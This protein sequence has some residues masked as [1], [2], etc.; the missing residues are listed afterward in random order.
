MPKSNNKPFR[1]TGDM[2]IADVIN[3]F[4]QTIEVFVKLGI[5]CIGCYVANFESIE[6]GV[7][8]HGQDPEKVVE[9]LNKAIK[10]QNVRKR[11]AAA[12]SGGKRNPDLS[13][14]R[15]PKR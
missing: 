4:P 3:A 10:T 11:T 1:I 6:E 7:S 8:R 2:V 13:R 12:K 9:L 15:K 5:H 14:S